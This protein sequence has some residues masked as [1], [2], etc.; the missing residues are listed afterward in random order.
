MK[1]L[2]LTSTCLFLISCT[3]NR[4][5][6]LGNDV[7]LY[8]ETPAWKL[9]KAV[10]HEHTNTIK[11]IVSKD[12]KL[13]NFQEP[14]FKQSLLEWAVY[15]N[16]FKSAQILAELG[17]DPNIQDISGTSAFIQAAAKYETS[18][19]VRLLLKHGGDVNAVSKAEK[20]QMRT[21]LIAASF[22]RLE[23][24]KL[25]VDAGADVNYMSSEHE[26]ALKSACIRSHIDI[27]YYLIVD[28]KADYKRAIG[29]N[30]NGDST[31]VSEWIS[32]MNFSPKSYLHEDSIRNEVLGYMERH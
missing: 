26:C 10:E 19:Y 5:N 7:R 15:T 20:Q 24:V 17:A 23:S 16:H 31:Y 9:A 3:T 18:D 4:S 28:K 22:N 30:A 11:E 2:L 6:M 27:V 1:T 14:K 29:Y 8:E 21:P 25:L 32:D 12:N 13:V